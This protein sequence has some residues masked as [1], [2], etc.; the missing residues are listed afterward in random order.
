MLNNDHSHTQPSAEAFI[1]CLAL[2]VNQTAHSINF[3]EIIYRLH[4][5]VDL[6]I[7]RLL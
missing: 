1:V 5:P 6:E 7:Y 3:F 4:H 2:N